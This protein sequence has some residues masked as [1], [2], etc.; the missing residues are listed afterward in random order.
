MDDFFPVPELVAA[1]FDLVGNT[2]QCNG[3]TSDPFAITEKRWIQ[4]SVRS[5]F[6]SFH[7][8]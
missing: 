6:V 4:V 3:Y 1:A 5:E 8:H 7:K 2:T